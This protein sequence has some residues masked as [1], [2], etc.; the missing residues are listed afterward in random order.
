[1]RGKHKLFFI[2]A[3]LTAVQAN[4]ADDWQRQGITEGNLP[5]SWQ[6]MKSQM[7]YPDSWL[8]GHYTDFKQWQQH[9]RQEFRQSLLTPDS[10]KPF[11]AK[12]IASEDRGSYTAE[13]LSLKHHR[14]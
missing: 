7:Q 14:R 8:S 3:M 4:A 6:Q 1:M 13:K 11:D 10:T 12:I 9:A 5:A 2:L